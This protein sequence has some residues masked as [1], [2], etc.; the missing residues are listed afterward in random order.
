MRAAERSNR[1]GDARSVVVRAASGD[2]IRRWIWPCGCLAAAFL[3]AFLTA[4]GRAEPPAFFGGDW[5]P[6]A[7]P[8]PTPAP[9]EPRRGRHVACYG[10]AY[11]PVYAK[12]VGTRLVESHRPEIARLQ[13]IEDRRAADAGLRPRSIEQE[14]R[15]G[16]FALV[17]PWKALLGYEDPGW[18]MHFCCRLRTWD[19]DGPS[20]IARAL[21]EWRAADRPGGEVARRLDAR[22]RRCLQGLC[23][24]PIDEPEI[25]DDRRLS[26]VEL[27]AAILAYDA[28][29]PVKGS[30]PHPRLRPARFAAALEARNEWFPP[31][32]HRLDGPSHHEARWILG[33]QLEIAGIDAARRAAALGRFDDFY[34]ALP[35]RPAVQR[36]AARSTRDRL[37][38]RAQR[39]ENEAAVCEGRAEIDIAGRMERGRSF[40][41]DLCH[42]LVVDVGTPLEGVVADGDCWGL[43]PTE[44]EARA[45]I[46]AL[47]HVCREEGLEAAVEEI[48]ALRRAAWAS[49]PERLPPV[50][51]ALLE[52]QPTPAELEVLLRHLRKV[53]PEEPPSWHP[54]APPEAAAGHDRHEAMRRLAE[55]C[56]AHYRGRSPD[57]RE[58]LPEVRE[59]ARRNLAG[60]LAGLRADEAEIGERPA[61]WEAA[62][63]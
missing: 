35:D 27:E 32:H 49:F 24:D 6:R 56:T 7:A 46:A 39:L 15:G 48:V 51:E 2:R 16:M 31:P 57:P 41:P 44:A 22:V 36:L 13:A 14:V 38:E 19:G 12:R 26:P 18:S 52:R 28:L 50:A 62:A 4:A 25:G 34:A 29:T 45:E 8:A 61:E 53:L 1:A 63:P 23:G 9:P 30:P 5:P 42:G 37:V 21:D 3:T 20:G 59:A 10:K 47:R 43:R 54:L 60:I 40:R 58:R 11:D 55:A 17:P 33:R